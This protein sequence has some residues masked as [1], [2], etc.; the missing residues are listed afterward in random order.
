MSEFLDQHCWE[1]STLLLFPGAL[2][3]MT[4]NNTDE[5]FSQGQLAVF[6]STNDDNTINVLLAPH[7]S[8]QL[9][10]IDTSH[11]EYFTQSWRCIRLSQNDSF[12]HSFYG[13]P[14]HNNQYLV[15]NCRDMT[16]QKSSGGE[17]LQLLTKISF[18]ENEYALWERP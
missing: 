12:N 5:Q 18:I 9:P 3:R 1:P 7:R 16:I 11:S 10:P 2:L 6:S 8:N 4:S 15:R 14:C 17:L 13:T